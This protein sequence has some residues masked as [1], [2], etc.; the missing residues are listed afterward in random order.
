MFGERE[1]SADLGENL[2]DI[3]IKED[4]KK[5]KEIDDIAAY[6]NLYKNDKEILTKKYTELLMDDNVVNIFTKLSHNTIFI[7]QF[8]EFYEKNINGE[9]VINC[10]QNSSYHRFG[11]FKHI[12]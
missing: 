8:P 9:N 12:L 1:V 10:Q 3:D 2:V 4:K 7:E 5:N 6:L 11:V